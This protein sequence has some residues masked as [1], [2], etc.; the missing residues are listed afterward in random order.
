MKKGERKL[1]VL[2]DLM[3]RKLKHDPNSK[4]PV[5][6]ADGGGLRIRADHRGKYWVYR[7]KMPNDSKDFVMGL[8]HYPDVSLE[9]A[10]KLR[11]TYNNLKKQGINPQM[12]RDSSV[13]ENLK[14]Y[15]QAST[16][17]KMFDKMMS[18]NS[19]QENWSEGNIKRYR[20]IFKNYL[21][22]SLGHLPLLTITADNLLF[23]LKDIR[24]NP[25]SLRSGKVDTKKYP[26]QVTLTYAKTV[27][28]L[29][30]Q[31]AI[32]WENF[33]GDNPLLKHKDH[34]LFKKIK[35]T[36]HKAVT[37][38]DLGHYWNEIKNLEILQDKA[39]M[40]VDLITGLRVGSLS[41]TTW[42]MFNPTKKTLS[43]PKE[44]LKTDVAFATPLPDSLVKDLM[45]LKSMGG[46]KKDDYIFTNRFGE[47][48]SPSR[49]RLLIKGFGFDAT[50]HGNR[51][52]LKLNASRF[53]NISS[54]AVEYQLTHTIATKDKVEGSYMG[55]YDWLDERRQLVDWF[56]EFLDTQ[57]S[58]YIKIKDLG[59]VNAR[60]D[61]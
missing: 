59:K 54:Y 45:I 47:H 41:K 48:Y 28:N 38:E 50:A 46:G 6:L 31:Y 21:S 22:K 5:Y 8:G 24:D 2:N 16:F 55:D 56:V 17:T 37:L 23:T 36:K 1:N 44:L 57:E 53:S 12:H 15:D 51:T 43:L 27:I 9:Q 4:K 52:I 33:S 11:D 34:S 10:R 39:F 3:I 60:V 18:H 32:E 40:M 20:S 58:N 35:P 13:N 29:V 25:V 19:K 49:P 26:R 30:Y 42:N 61:V 14:K 7:F